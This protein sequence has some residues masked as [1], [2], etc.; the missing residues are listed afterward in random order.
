M[1]GEPGS[2]LALSPEAAPQAWIRMGARY[3][4]LVERLIE[5]SA[6]HAKEWVSLGAEVLLRQGEH[7]AL[8]I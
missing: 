4:G 3:L 5:M 7:C 2:A 6:E 1:L 8:S